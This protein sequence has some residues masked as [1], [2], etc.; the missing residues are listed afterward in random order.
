[1]LGYNQN[2]Q[3]PRVTMWILFLALLLELLKEILKE[4]AKKILEVFIS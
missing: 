3:T 2:I 4:L 1:M